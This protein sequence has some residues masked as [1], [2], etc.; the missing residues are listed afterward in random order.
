MMDVV[1]NKKESIERCIRQINIYYRMPSDKPF[2]KDYFKQ[3]AIAANLQRA[4][5]QQP[6][7]TLVDQILKIK[8]KVADADTSTLEREI[9]AMV[10]ALYGFTPEEVEIV[11]GRG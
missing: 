5:E 4:A 9:D 8:Q 1:L 10:Y 11:E 7:I 3:D 6:F 2:E